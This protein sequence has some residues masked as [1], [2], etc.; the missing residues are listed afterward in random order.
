MG[1]IAG[2]VWKRQVFQDRYTSGDG[3][4]IIQLARLLTGTLRT[5]AVAFSLQLIC[6]ISYMIENSY[7]SQDSTDDP[8]TL[9][10]SV[11][12]GRQGCRWGEGIRH[13]V[14]MNPKGN[15]GE[16]QHLPAPVA[17]ASVAG[18]FADASG[19]ILLR[20][21]FSGRKFFSECKTVSCSVD[22]TRIG[23]KEICL[24]I[25]SGSTDDLRRNAA[26]VMPPQVLPSVMPEEPC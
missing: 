16:V 20:Y 17:A 6:L 10:T 24:G 15:K 25:L 13:V 22:C 12:G 9:E 1:S 19:K 21:L 3:A 23:T 7:N 2:A 14:I 18:R 4:D 11:G 5:E 26:M 8:R